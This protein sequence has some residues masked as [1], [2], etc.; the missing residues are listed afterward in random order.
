MHLIYLKKKK[1]KP[2]K[3]GTFSRGRSVLA[4]IC[5]F[6]GFGKGFSPQRL[7]LKG[8]CLALTQ[9]T[10]QQRSALGV[11]ASALRKLQLC[12]ISVGSRL[13]HPHLSLQ[14]VVLAPEK[15]FKV[16]VKRRIPH[17]LHVNPFLLW[18]FCKISTSHHPSAAGSS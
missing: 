3:I 10:V 7:G 2:L 11:N 6:H 9:R 8:F 16:M 5:C 12:A 15:N 14:E 1:T 4:D 17:F 18:S 13:G